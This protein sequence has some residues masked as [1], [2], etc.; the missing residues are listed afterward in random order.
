[1]DR[2]TRIATEW[3]DTVQVMVHAL[4]EHTYT[5]CGANPRYSSD[6][7]LLQEVA[8]LRTVTCGD[9]QRMLLRWRS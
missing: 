9:C 8:D 2:P 7:W 4:T 1:M 5:L 6:H 3:P